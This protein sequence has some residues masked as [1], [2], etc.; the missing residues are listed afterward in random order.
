MLLRDLLNATKDGDWGLGSP[1][2]GYVPFHVIRG[3]DFPEIAAGETSGIPIRYLDS[4]S[5][6][7]RRLQPNDIIIET[8][9]GNRDRPTGR[10]L[11]VTNRL[12]GALD[13]PATCASFCRFLRVDSSKADP[14]FVYWYLQYLYM[15]GEM[16]VHQVQHTG[17]ARFQYTRFADSVHIP[18]PSLH[19]QSSVS[20][21]LCGLDEKIE[22]NRRMN[23][24]LELMASAIFKSWFV[25]FDPVHAKAQG[26]HPFG[27]AAVTAALFS[28]SFQQSPLGSIP[29]GW[30]VS[31]LGAE[32]RR[33]GGQIQTGP[34]GS[35]LHASDYVS[36][37]GIPVVMP[38]N[39]TNRRVS[40]R[41]IARI[42]QVDAERLSKH[43]VE[44]GDIVYSRRGD[45]ER[46][47]WITN[48]E[49]G[50][51]CGTGCLLVRMGPKWLAPIFVSF[52]LDR[53]ESRAWISQRAIGATMPNLNTSTLFDFP[54]V[55]PPDPILGALG[56]VMG[57][58]ELLISANNGE[59]QTLAG[60]RDALL[61]KLLSGRV[62]MR[63]GD[64]IAEASR[65]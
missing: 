11:L 46:H 21:A 26:R 64:E 60:L 58:V 38:K 18:L 23:E 51:L 37:P 16:W 47:A 27:I 54:L 33:C 12:L 31:T 1:K 7:R 34:F 28:D 22:L 49:V 41:D 45:V 55:V 9:G 63:E 13:L 19:V 8:A 44:V 6:D 52:T 40:T 17:V 4:R 59:S 39:I 62:P 25:D 24:S 50:W 36:A 48:N 20:D 42:T 15:Q 43:R 3:A 10:T 35:Q 61:T 65:V 53:P 32:V 5:V 56:D 57:P 29:A 14:R 2:D 30:R